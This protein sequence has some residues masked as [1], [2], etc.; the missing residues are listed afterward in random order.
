MIH[1]T[2][3]F[4]QLAVHLEACLVEDVFHGIEHLVRKDPLAVLCHKDEMIKILIN[5]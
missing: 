4:Q 2:I 5:A 1:F 3:A